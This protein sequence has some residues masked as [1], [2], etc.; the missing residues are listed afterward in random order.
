MHPDDIRRVTELLRN[1]YVIK[2]PV[3]QSSSLG[4]GI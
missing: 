1:D 4:Q 2:V 3:C